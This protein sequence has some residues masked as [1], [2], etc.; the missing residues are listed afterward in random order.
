[1]INTLME[2]NEKVEIMSDNLQVV[3]PNNS[4]TI[5]TDT[6]NH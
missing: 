4:V 5:S 6:E 1:M 3:N 2:N